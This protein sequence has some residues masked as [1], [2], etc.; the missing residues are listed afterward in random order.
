MIKKLKDMVINVIE[1]LFF[2]F[3]NVVF[4]L[5]LAVFL[6]ILNKYKS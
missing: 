2:S 1:F 5:P 6:M 4:V 3:I